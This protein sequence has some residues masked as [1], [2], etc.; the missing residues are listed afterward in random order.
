MHVLLALIEAFLPEVARALS[1]P[2]SQ[3]L[4]RR[5]LRAGIG[6]FLIVAGHVVVRMLWAVMVTRQDVSPDI[7]QLGERVFLA[8]V[9]L[10]GVLCILLSRIDG[11]KGA[12]EG[13]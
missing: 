9:F 10:S 7:F 8:I 3:P 1:G 4:R 6:F 13:S 11:S 5:L 12:G 2:A